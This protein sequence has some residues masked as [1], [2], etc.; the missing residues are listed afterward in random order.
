[1]GRAYTV[2][3]FVAD[4]PLSRS[5]KSLS[6]R[7]STVRM[8]RL[9]QP[10]CKIKFLKL[11]ELYQYELLETHITVSKFKLFSVLLLFFFNIIYDI[12]EF[13][14]FL[15][16]PN[17]YI[18]A[19]ENKSPRVVRLLNKK[20]LPPRDPKDLPVF[21]HIEEA[22]PYLKRGGYAFHC[23]VVDAYPEIAKQF[24][25][26]E[27]CDLRAVSGLLV[28]ELLNSVVHKNSQY[29]ELFRVII[30]ISHKTYSF[31]SVANFFQVEI[32]HVNAL[33]YILDQMEDCKT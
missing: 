19:E 29:T 16:V 31:Y 10:L 3:A 27:I 15:N 8:T 26:S 12:V 7:S 24:E 18:S 33:C 30:K 11:N 23:E 17:I 28:T 13:P 21:T 20:V 14:A 22:I 1:M 9:I 5:I 4:A 2:A 25:A 6:D 32:P